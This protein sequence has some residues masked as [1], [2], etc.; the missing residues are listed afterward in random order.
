MSCIALD[1]PEVQ[2]DIAAIDKIAAFPSATGILHAS[3][4]VHSDEIGLASIGACDSQTGAIRYRQASRRADNGF[5]FL[6]IQIFHFRHIGC[7]AI[8]DDIAVTDGNQDIRSIFKSRL[9]L[10]N[11][12]PTCD[13]EFPTVQGHFTV[14]VNSTSNDGLFVFLLWRTEIQL[15]VIGN[16]V[17]FSRGNIV[18]KSIVGGK[19]N[20]AITIVINGSAFC[21]RCNISL[22]CTAGNVAD[23]SIIGDSSSPV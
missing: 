12:T 4:V 10:F 13:F 22:K 1:T 21:A 18:F 6:S 20:G 5:V 23:T 15:A 19:G 9:S 7:I 3:S 14:S 8:L 17:R 16:I 2:Q 11:G